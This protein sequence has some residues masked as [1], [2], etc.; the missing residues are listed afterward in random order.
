[1]DIFDKISEVKGEPESKLVVRLTTSMWHDKNGLHMRRDVR[2]LKRKSFGYNILYEDA[3]WVGAD[4][5][6][7]RIVNLYEADDGVYEVITVNE[8]E[9]WETGCIED[10]D[11]KLIEI[12]E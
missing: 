6:I 7:N 9:D 12:G 11:Y 4:E 5:V 2:F 1:M 8:S 10:Y 3:T